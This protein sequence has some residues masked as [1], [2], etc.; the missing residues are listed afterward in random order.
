MLYK[1]RNNFYHFDIIILTIF[2]SVTGPITLVGMAVGLLVSGTV[3]SKYK[4]GPRILLGWNVIIGVFFVLGEVGFL[5]LSCP[6]TAIQG[7]D[8]NSMQ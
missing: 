7:I 4:P 6:G 1:L 8:P 5:F 3:I 2:V